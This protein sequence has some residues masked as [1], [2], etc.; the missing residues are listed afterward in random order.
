MSANIIC[1]Q[2]LYLTADKTALVAEGDKRAAFLFAHPGDEIVAAEHNRFGLVD[3]ALPDFE[4]AEA[5]VKAKRPPAN[6][7]KPAAENKEA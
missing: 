5:T 1:T 4:A 2:R 7:A 6:K 3:G